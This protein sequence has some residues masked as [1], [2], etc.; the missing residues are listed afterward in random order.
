ME[1]NFSSISVDIIHKLE[2][3]LQKIK[4]NMIDDINNFIYVLNDQQVI[5]VKGQINQEISDIFN[6]EINKSM[7]LYTE[8]MNKVQ[9]V[10]AKY[11]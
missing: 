6:D 7:I 3:K 2:K 8:C 1:Y 4:D 9:R 11:L 10:L 5:E